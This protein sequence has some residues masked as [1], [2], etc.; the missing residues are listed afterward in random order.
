MGLI[1]DL[2]RPELAFLPIG[3]HF[4]MDPEQGARA[5]RLLNVQRVIPIHWGTF[6]LLRGTPA[7]LARALMD[8]GSST[9]VVALR[10]GESWAP[11]D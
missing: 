9:T 1:G 4:T 7:D 5:C 3:D 11:A 6:P 10:P 8:L 2:W